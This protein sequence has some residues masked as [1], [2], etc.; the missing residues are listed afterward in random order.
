MKGEKMLVGITHIDNNLID[1][2]ESYKKRTKEQIIK[3][4][5]R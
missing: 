3:Q 2:A 5:Y 4:F 1:F